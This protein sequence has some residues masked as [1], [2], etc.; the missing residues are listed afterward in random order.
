MSK[1]DSLSFNN[2]DALTVIKIIKKMQAKITVEIFLKNCFSS[3][4]NSKSDANKK[5]RRKRIQYCK[6]FGVTRTSK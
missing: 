4:E 1:A 3:N 2:N 6:S 5:K